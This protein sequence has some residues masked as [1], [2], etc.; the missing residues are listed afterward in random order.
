MSWCH[1]IYFYFMYL[2]HP[3]C[4]GTLII[5]HEPK[6]NDPTNYD[7]EFVS[8]NL[9]ENYYPR[10]SLSFLR[11]RNVV[12]MV[13]VGK[14][15]CWHIRHFYDTAVKPMHYEHLGANFNRRYSQNGHLQQQQTSIE[16]D[17]GNIFSYTK[18]KIWYREIV[19]HRLLDI[20]YTLDILLLIDCT[21]DPGSTVIGRP[22]P[23]DLVAN[24]PCDMECLKE[25]E[26]IFS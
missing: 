25:A 10:R 3:D 6:T 11:E 4:E 8:T 18:S 23:Q 24:S 1:L 21:Y 16:K 7:S 26:D 5:Y 19:S 13:N 12:G 22:K 2:G 9:T 20:S 17:P 15:C 14:N